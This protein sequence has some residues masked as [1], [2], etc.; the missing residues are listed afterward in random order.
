MNPVYD[1]KGRVALLTGASSGI[2]LRPRRLSPRR[3]GGS[4]RRGKVV[5]VAV[6]GF[7][8]EAIESTEKWVSLV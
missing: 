4:A 8:A 5:D 1:F 7:Q 6:D 3:A 2:G